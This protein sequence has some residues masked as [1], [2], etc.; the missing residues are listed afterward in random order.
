MQSKKDSNDMPLA[1]LK[2]TD[3]E[4]PDG[5]AVFTFEGSDEDFELIVKTGIRDMINKDLLDVKD[6][7][8][9]N[10][11]ELSE[12]EQFTNYFFSYTVKTGLMNM[13]NDF[14]KEKQKDMFD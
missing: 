11:D 6:Y 7:L 5:S 13:L 9:P 14:E 3:T 8:A 12:E 2:C 10:F 1:S 4:L